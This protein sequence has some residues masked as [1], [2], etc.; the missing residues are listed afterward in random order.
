MS[1]YMMTMSEKSRE[2]RISEHETMVVS[3]MLGQGRGLSIW[4]RHSLHVCILLVTEPFIELL[5]D[6]FSLI[7]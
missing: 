3:N 1:R 5:T 2:G 6:S 4:L 7:V